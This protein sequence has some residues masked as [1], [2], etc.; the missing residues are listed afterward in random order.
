MNKDEY[1]AIVKSWEK[2]YGVPSRAFHYDP[3][4]V[5]TTCQKCKQWKP[6]MARHHKANDFFFAY[7]FPA[8]YAARYIQFH[9]EDC[10]KLCDKCHKI[11]HKYFYALAQEMYLEFE[12]E[13]R[14]IHRDSSFWQNW[15]DE[16]RDRFLEL[17]N[18]WISKPPYKK[19]RRKK[20]H[21]PTK[22]E[23]RK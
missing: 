1:F 14:I 11:C 3:T 17:Y 2:K 21:L 23:N 10:D 19:R 7:N 22:S 18:R 6:K 8:L 4:E 12:G 9:K 16:W 20:S 5:K 15:C 13:R